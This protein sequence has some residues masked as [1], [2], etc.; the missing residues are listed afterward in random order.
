[1]TRGLFVGRF[2][3]FHLGHLHVIKELLEKVDE[4]IIAIG[5]PSTVI[6]SRILLMRVRGFGWLEVH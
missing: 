4:L 6:L 3:P 2:Q 1:M 5:M